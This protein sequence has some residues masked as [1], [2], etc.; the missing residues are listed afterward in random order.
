MKIDPEDLKGT[1]L[2]IFVNKW[3]QRTVT[4]YEHISDPTLL[5]TVGRPFDGS[6]A[7]VCVEPRRDWEATLT[8]MKAAVVQE[9]VYIYE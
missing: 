8:K 4:V 5:I 3:R 2:G 7:I 9:R 1:Y 6:K